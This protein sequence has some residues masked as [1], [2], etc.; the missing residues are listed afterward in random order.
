[1]DSRVGANGAALDLVAG[2]ERVESLGHGKA[3]YMGRMVQPR[4]EQIT[5]LFWLKKTLSCTTNRRSLRMNLSR[6][7]ASSRMTSPGRAGLL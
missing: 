2:R 7:R 5:S 4:P 3:P 1:M 6:A